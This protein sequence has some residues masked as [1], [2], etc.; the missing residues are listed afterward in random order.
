MRH[1]HPICT[2]VN[3]DTYLISSQT[4]VDTILKMQC[5]FA[6]GRSPLEAARRNGH[7][8]VVRLLEAAGFTLKHIF[9][10][11]PILNYFRQ[12]R[13]GE[14]EETEERQVKGDGVLF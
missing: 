4:Y 3:D 6:T 5:R 2:G 7:E 14:A 10:Q 12:I 8:E 9:G 1:H 13:D 11:S